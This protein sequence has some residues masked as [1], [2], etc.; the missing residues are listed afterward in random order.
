[1]AVKKTKKKL[2]NKP[3]TA[4]QMGIS[5]LSVHGGEERRKYADSVTVPIVQTSTFVFQDENDIREYTSGKKKRFEYARYGNPTTRTAELKLAAL[6]G[7]EDALLFDCGMSAVSTSLLSMLSSGDHIVITS[8]VYKKTLQ[9]VKNDLSRFGISN[10]IVAPRAEDIESAI[11]PETKLIFSESPTNPYVYVL[12]FKKLAAVAKKAG[13]P[14]FVDSTFAT[15]YNVRPLEFGI[16]MV[17]HSATKY[18]AGHNDIMAGV[19]L[20]SAERINKVKMFQK[21]V[22][23]CIDAHASYLLL[24]G[25]KTFALRVSHQNESALAVARFLENH[26]RIKRVWYPGLPS[27]PSHKIA[28]SQMRGFGGCLSFE[29][30]SNMSGVQKFLRNLRLCQM[31]PSLGGTETLITHPATITY[32]DMT[33]PARLKLGITDQ[34]V[35]LAVGVED[36]EDIIAD[37]DAALSS[38]K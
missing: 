16:D 21:T 35:R 19:V 23:G 1:M 5:T 7:A 9:F 15:P 25:L 2:S 32:Y 33:R 12:D 24:R 28:K 6:E 10:S 3:A 18:L 20:G 4:K 27:H 30:N 22:G 31:G 17:M 36:P 37:L 8:D 38:L 14:T 11:R 13:V 34:L 26:S 29:V